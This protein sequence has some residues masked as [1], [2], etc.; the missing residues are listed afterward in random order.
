M[1]ERRFPRRLNATVP[2]PETY[3][4]RFGVVSVHDIAVA[5]EEQEQVFFGVEGHFGFGPGRCHRLGSVSGVVC[6]L[7][8]DSTHLR[9]CDKGA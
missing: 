2:S 7:Y 4:F 5:V 1:Q 6:R 9:E 3:G 8:I